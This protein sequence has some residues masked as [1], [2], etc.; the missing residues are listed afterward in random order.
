[1]NISK[2]NSIST[3]EWLIV[4]LNAKYSKLKGQILND[5]QNTSSPRVALSPTLLSVTLT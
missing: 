1:M 5:I 3:A 2:K 4:R